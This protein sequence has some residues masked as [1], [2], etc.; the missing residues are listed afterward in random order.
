MVDP[1]LGGANIP[2]NLSPQR[3]L[4]NDYNQDLINVYRGIRDTPGGLEINWGQHTDPQGILPK[5]AF[6]EDIRGGL[7]R[8]KS[9]A[10]WE[11]VWPPKEGSLNSIIM[12]GHEQGLSSER[13][14]DMAQAW[15]KMQQAAFQGHA[16][17][18]PQGYYNI[19]AGHEGPYADIWNY[20]HYQ[21]L[22]ENWEL[23]SKPIDQ[24]MQEAELNPRDDFMPLDPPYLGE[25]GAY[26]VGD[27]HPFDHFQQPLADW[28]GELAEDGM[29][30]VAFN[31]AHAQDMWADRGFD[32]ALH[33]RMD[34][35]G[36]RGAKREARPEL[37]AFANIPDMDV[38]RWF[39][40]HPDK[41]WVTE[42][43]FRYSND[44]F[45]DAWSVMKGGV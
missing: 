28:A 33:A 11:N 16:R 9:G 24:F 45:E 32:T 26:N 27:K 38:E 37:V 18:N 12:E 35:T 23:Q 17:S 36:G 21:P 44:V 31:S 39:R 6:M 42:D 8:G 4:L 7:K 34:T 3:T 41:Q 30:I 40:H 20:K 15:L 19:A 29:P 43:L 25:P 2:L 5:R 13:I 22:M 14:H 1:F 10:D